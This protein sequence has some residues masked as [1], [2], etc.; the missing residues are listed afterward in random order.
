MFVTVTTNAPQNNTMH[1]TS[2]PPTELLGARPGKTWATSVPSPALRSRRTPQS[3]RP[4][5]IA[6]RVHRLRS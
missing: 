4:Y 6:R 5:S 1:A 2:H 3:P